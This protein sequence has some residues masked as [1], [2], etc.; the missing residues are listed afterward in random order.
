[1]KIID[2]NRAVTPYWIARDEFVSLLADKAAADPCITVLEGVTANQLELVQ[3]KV[4]S[5][6]ALAPAS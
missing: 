5:N 6:K 3:G 2:P 4:C 1:M